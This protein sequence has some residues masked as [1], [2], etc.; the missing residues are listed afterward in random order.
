MDDDGTQKVA[1]IIA[2]LAAFISPFMGS[3]INIALP[4]IGQEFHMDAVMLGWV[5]TAYLLSSA[6]CLLPFGRAADIYGR[7]K[8]FTYGISVFTIGSLLSALATSASMLIVFRVIQ[9]MGGAMIFGTSVAIL[10]SVYPPQERGRVLGINAAFVYLGLSLGPFLG[11]FLTHHLGWRSIFYIY[12]PFGALIIFLIFWKLKGE[13]AGARGEKMDVPGAINYSVSLVLLIYGLS[14]IPAVSGICLFFIGLVGLMIFL[15]WEA[16][17]KSPIF[18]IRAF[19]TNI[20]FAFSNLAALIHYS[21]TF[22]VTFLLSLYLQYN[23]GLNA[24]EAGLVLISQPLMMAIFSPIAG[25]LSDRI[26]P[27]LVSSLGMTFTCLALFLLSLIQRQT[28][29]AYLVVVLLFSGF[30]YALFSSPNTNA[31]MSSVEPK[32][33]GVASATLGSM[34]QVGMMFSMGSAMMVFAIFIGKVQITPDLYAM[35]LKS[36]KILFV[37][38]GI[39]CIAG[40]FSSM[41]RGKIH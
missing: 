23:K 8:I 4:T 25:R 32:F 21:A 24:Q 1:L 3:S 9:G 37:S 10:T 5:A 13:W 6:M 17:A 29:L 26:E 7:K 15:W 39:L 41:A 11:G 12:I 40:I 16:R 33:Y 14:K 28:S 18:N 2:C 19:R 38:F 27:R 35:F 36:A 30:G 31:V 22:A 34:R 20:V